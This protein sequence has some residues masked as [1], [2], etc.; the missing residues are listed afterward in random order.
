LARTYLIFGDFEGTFDML[1]V[2]GFKLLGGLERGQ[3]NNVVGLTSSLR[4]QFR[5]SSQRQLRRNSVEN[6]REI[7]SSSVYNL[8]Q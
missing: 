6:C 7:L 3:R 8:Q 2:D 1:R 4:A 5:S